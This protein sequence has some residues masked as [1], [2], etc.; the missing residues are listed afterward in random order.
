M[1]DQLRLNIS[2][3]ANAI[4]DEEVIKKLRDYVVAAGDNLELLAGYHRSAVKKYDALKA[5]AI[6]KIDAKLKVLNDNVAGQTVG[7]LLGAAKTLGRYAEIERAIDAKIAAK[8][9]TVAAPQATA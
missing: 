1:A 5:E 9:A 6:A 4:G 7:N 3:R 8:N 2:E